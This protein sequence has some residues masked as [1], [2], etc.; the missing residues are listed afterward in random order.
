ML[1]TA[2]SASRQIH[3]SSKDM[4]NINYAT[5]LYLIEHYK[6]HC[7]PTM[8][9]KDIWIKE[10]MAMANACTRQNGKP[11]T[12]LTLDITKWVHLSV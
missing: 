6:L 7:W 3:Y 9:Q 11:V 4:I 10:V 12:D 1:S 2:S 5:W 8:D